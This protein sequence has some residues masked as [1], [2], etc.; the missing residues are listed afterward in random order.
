MFSQNCCSPQGGV[1]AAHSS[2]SA[3]NTPG[4]RAALPPRDPEL[5]PQHDAQGQP[6]E[7]SGHCVGTRDH[8]PQAGATTRDGAG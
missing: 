6:G 2:T 1:S 5:V 7:E 3:T 4:S 8:V